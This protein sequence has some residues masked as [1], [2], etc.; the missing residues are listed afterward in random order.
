MQLRDS[1][2][3]YH[4]MKAKY[5]I[6]M[7][8]VQQLELEKT[9]LAQQLEKSKVD[10]TQGCSTAIKKELEKVEQSLLRARNETR[11]HRQMYR[12]AEQEAQR[13]RVLERKVTDL[14]TGK[15]QLMKKQKA[16]AAKHREYTETKTVEIMSLKRKER[17]TEKKVTMLQTEIQKHKSQ[18][19]KRQTYCSKL[20]GKLKQTESHLMKLLSM[21]QRDLHDRT[22]STAASRRRSSIVQPP[23]NRDDGVF[24][25]STEETAS[26]NFIFDKA[27]A[28]KVNLAEMKSRYEERVAEYSETMQDGTSR[29][30]R[31]PRAVI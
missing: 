29:W 25:P 7:A 23:R 22:S 17:H 13:C 8:E 19:Q 15:A 30:R 26:I 27:V 5:E 18:L 28:E 10:P 4:D 14:K 9:Q 3:I 2:K 24:A 20:T 6:L 16:A 12:K 11:K 31:P 1:L 21:R